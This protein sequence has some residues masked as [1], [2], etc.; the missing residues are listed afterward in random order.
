MGIVGE[1][2]RVAVIVDIE[3]VEEVLGAERDAA[4]VRLIPEPLPGA[5]VMIIA[6]SSR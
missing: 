6:A 5:G 4:E 2:D 3:S 1:A